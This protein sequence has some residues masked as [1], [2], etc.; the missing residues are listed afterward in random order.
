M[1][2]LTSSL[3]EDITR[4]TVQFPY[5]GARGGSNYLDSFGDDVTYAHFCERIVRNGVGNRRLHIAARA[6]LTGSIHESCCNRG[7]AVLGH[8]A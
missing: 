8:E 5:V 2:E 3:V 1:F 7:I 4:E 6:L